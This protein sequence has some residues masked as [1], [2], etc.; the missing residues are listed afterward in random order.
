MIEG[1]FDFVKVNFIVVGLCCCLEFLGNI[2]LVK[3]IVFGRVLFIE[4]IFGGI[5]LIIIFIKN[6]LIFLNN[7]FLE[8][9]YWLFFVSKFNKM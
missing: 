2:F 8:I 9:I 1:L 5:N 4:F 6:I 3:G 7:I